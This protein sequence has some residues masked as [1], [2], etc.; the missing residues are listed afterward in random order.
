MPENL[1]QKTSPTKSFLDHYMQIHGYVMTLID[2]FQA[3]PACII[4]EINY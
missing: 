2:Y 1:V 3:L 4:F